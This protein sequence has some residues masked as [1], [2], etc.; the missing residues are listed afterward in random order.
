MA[1]RWHIFVKFFVLA[2]LCNSFI[3][4]S[5]GS[6]L[7]KTITFVSKNPEVKN[8]E[9]KI[10]YPSSLDCTWDAPWNGGIASAEYGTCSMT[11]IKYELINI[12]YLDLSKLDDS[13]FMWRQIYFVNGKTITLPWQRFSAGLKWAFARDL[14]SYNDTPPRF[15]PSG[16]MQIE[17]IGLE[18]LN[19]SVVMNSLPRIKLWGPAKADPIEQKGTSTKQAVV[20][21]NSAYQKWEFDR[22]SDGIDN[23]IYVDQE[24]FDDQITLRIYCEKKRIGA[25]ISA[26]YAN[27]TGWRGVAQ[28]RFD[29]K[30]VKKLS[31]TVNRQFDT[32]YIDNPRAFISEFLK[33]KKVLIKIGTVDGFQLST[34]YQ[35][36][37]K[38]YKKQFS[39]KGCNIG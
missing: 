16:E 33:S 21:D 10:T 11:S 27:S 8:L 29:S 25:W 39:A 34:F 17:F 23:F 1:L 14:F 7:S 35:L 32:I 30:P 5:Y 4:T 15:Y 31:Y 19:Y 13:Q 18:S 6:E 26:E 28:I 36:N 38:S 12:G 24:I 20:D 3:A 22:Y 37:L 2:I 9:M